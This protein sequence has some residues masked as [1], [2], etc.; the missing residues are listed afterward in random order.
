MRILSFDAIVLKI[1]LQHNP[2]RSRLVPRPASGATDDAVDRAPE[3]RR[4]AIRERTNRDT[5]LERSP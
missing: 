1:G 4:K 5:L 3:N 2:V